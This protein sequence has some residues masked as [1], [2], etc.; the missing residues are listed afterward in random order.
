MG[1]EH[2]ELFTD[3]E[4][5]GEISVISLVEEAIRFWEDHLDAVDRL[6]EKYRQ[7]ADD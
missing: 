2:A 7:C 1:T 6:A 3:Y 5:I 4:G